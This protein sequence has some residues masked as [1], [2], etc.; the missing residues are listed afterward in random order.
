MDEVPGGSGWGGKHGGGHNTKDTLGMRVREAG[1]LATNR[2]SFGRAREDSDVLKATC[3]KK[4][5]PLEL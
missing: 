2:E 3:D 4:K 1:E 5:S